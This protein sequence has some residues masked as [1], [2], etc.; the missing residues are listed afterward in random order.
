MDVDAD[1]L[2][3]ATSNF[4]QFEDLHI[5]LLHAD[6]AQLPR[7]LCADTVV[8]C[9]CALACFRQA[10]RADTCRRSNPPFGTRRKGADTEFL[11]AACEIASHAVYSLHKA[12]LKLCKAR[13]TSEPDNHGCCLTVQTSTREHVQRFADSTL[14]VKSKVRFGYP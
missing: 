14:R 9:A 5:D 6:V 7:R 2:Q 11:Q 1:A 4:A 8:T 13:L 3:I 12:R 10:T